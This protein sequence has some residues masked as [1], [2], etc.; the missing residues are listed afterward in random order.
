MWLM[1]LHIC[2]YHHLPN[3]PSSFPLISPWPG[4]RSI[5]DVATT[6]A[7]WGDATWS[8][9][10]SV[11]KPQIQELFDVSF[12]FCLDDFIIF[13]HI[14]HGQNLS[15]IVCLVTWIEWLV[16]REF[17]SA[18]FLSV[19]F[20]GVQLPPCWVAWSKLLKRVVVVNS[21][22]PW[23]CDMW[24]VIWVESRRDKNIKDRIWIIWIPWINMDHVAMNC[25]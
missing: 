23:M 13:I 14:R 1:W 9:R 11:G 8:I 22:E 17:L 25:R 24:N 5:P 21:F 15:M 10:Q 12:D 3:L 4:G 7:A 2:F 16:E 18:F 19:L 6:P 20:K